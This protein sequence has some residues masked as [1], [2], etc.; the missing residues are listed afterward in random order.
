MFASVTGVADKSSTLTTYTP[1][2]PS[3]GSLITFPLL[4]ELNGFHKERLLNELQQTFGH[5]KIRDI[6]FR[7]KTEL[8]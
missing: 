6:K 3:I 2:T 4:A 7:L 5:L 8:K 1:D